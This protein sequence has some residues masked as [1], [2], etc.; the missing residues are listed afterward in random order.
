MIWLTD[1]NSHKLQ[2]Q[3]CVIKCISV[4]D[5][6]VNI[7]SPGNKYNMKIKLLLALLLDI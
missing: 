4:N 6:D 3:I 7:P 5:S 1:H 2:T